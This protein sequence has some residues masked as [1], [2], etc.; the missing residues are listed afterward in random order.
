MVLS[1]PRSFLGRGEGRLLGGE[2][3][4]VHGPIGIRAGLPDM[5]IMHGHFGT[6]DKQEARLGLCDGGVLPGE[7]D[8]ADGRSHFGAEDFD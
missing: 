8:A 3:G 2:D 4:A 5:Q 7:G 6:D 1:L